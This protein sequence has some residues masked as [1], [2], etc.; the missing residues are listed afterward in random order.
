MKRSQRY[1]LVN[2]YGH[3]RSPATKQKTQFIGLFSLQKLDCNR[4]RLWCI[5]THWC[6]LIFFYSQLN[7]YNEKN[8]NEEKNCLKPSRFAE[9]SVFKSGFC[10][11]F[12][13]LREIIVK[14]VWNFQKSS[15]IVRST[16]RSSLLQFAFFLRFSYNYFQSKH[17]GTSFLTTVSL[18]ARYKENIAWKIELKKTI[19]RS[20]HWC[21]SF[22]NEENWNF[23]ENCCDDNSQNYRCLHHCLRMHR[24]TRKKNNNRTTKADP[25]TR[26][27]ST[28]EKKK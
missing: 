23:H 18:N 12:V 1:D 15:F 24:T 27:R 4:H 20:V 16:E 25:N 6:V 10:C 7:F 26:K 3:F 11:C 8:K 28:M 22:V 14:F 5:H 19:S 21:S 13:F 17:R 9:R 2:A